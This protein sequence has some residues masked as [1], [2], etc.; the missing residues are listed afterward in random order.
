MKNMKSIELLPNKEERLPGFS[1]D[2]PYIST[3]AQIDEYDGRLVPW[4]W[5]R[6]VEL[7]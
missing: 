2:F 6:T 7:V 3:R 4:H 5:P 1:F